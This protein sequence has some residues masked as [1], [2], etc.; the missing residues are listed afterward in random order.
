MAVSDTILKRW[1]LVALAASAAM[2]AAAHA[3]QTFGHLAPCHMCLKQREAYWIAMVAAAAAIA[4][5]L[6]PLQGRATRVGC[7]VLALVFVY[8]AY[9]AGWQAGAEWKW[10]AA[11]ATCASTGV[12]VTVADLKALMAGGGGATPACDKA[13]WVFLGLSMAG[14]NF[15]VSVALAALSAVAALRR[16]DA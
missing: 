5:G 11:P 1:P 16:T 2:L 7:A 9:W 12:R 4:L 14:W 3:F 15:L 6:T 13:P 8:G 10:W